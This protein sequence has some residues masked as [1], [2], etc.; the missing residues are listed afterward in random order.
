MKLLKITGIVKK[1]TTYL[2][3]SCRLGS[4]EHFFFKYSTQN[5]LVTKILPK[6][7][8]QGLSQE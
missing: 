3:E 5:V 7:S 4:D 8:I 6:W 2:K 1:L